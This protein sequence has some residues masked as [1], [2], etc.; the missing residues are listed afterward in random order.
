MKERKEGRLNF[1][2]ACTHHARP[3]NDMAFPRESCLAL[4][5]PRIEAGCGVFFH[6]IRRNGMTSFMELMLIV[7]SMTEVN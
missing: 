4:P 1:Y 5:S 2:K 7:V 3:E 6:E